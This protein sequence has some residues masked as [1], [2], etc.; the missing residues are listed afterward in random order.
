MNNSK[1]LEY[2]ALLEFT[3]IYCYKIIL[4]LQTKQYTQ[5][6]LSKILKLQPQNTSKY[7]KELEKLNLIKVSKIEGRN[8]FFEAVNCEDIEC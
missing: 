6:Q 2:I 5:A 1:Y 7:V 8:K 4:L 3:S